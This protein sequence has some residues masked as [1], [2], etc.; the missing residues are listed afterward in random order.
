MSAIVLVSGTIRT[1]KPLIKRNSSDVFAQ[2]V[3]VLT[4]HGSHMGETLEV[5]VFDPREGEQTVQAN[6]G[7]HVVWVIEVEA[8]SFGL[9][10]RYRGEGGSE[11][12]LPSSSGFNFFGADAATPE[13]ASAV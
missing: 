5:T 12:A 2:A 13:P 4:E 7:D 3:S 1:K 11:A 8:S 9:R 6:V 10:G